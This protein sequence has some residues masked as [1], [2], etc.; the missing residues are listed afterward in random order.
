ML[1]TLI[2]SSGVVDIE[3]VELRSRHLANGREVR[4]GFGEISDAR[5]YRRGCHRHPPLTAASRSDVRMMTNSCHV[6]SVGWWVHLEARAT[7]TEGARQRRRSLERAVVEE[8]RLRWN[9][10]SSRRRRVKWLRR[11]SAI[12]LNG[13]TLLPT[14]SSKSPR[15]NCAVVRQ[16]VTG[17]N[18]PIGQPLTRLFHA[19]AASRCQGG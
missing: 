4:S 7:V 13:L 19:D 17:A 15:M 10:N 5:H 9:S 16:G 3:D 1:S 18:A 2:T 14:K 6:V 8:S 11:T 12:H